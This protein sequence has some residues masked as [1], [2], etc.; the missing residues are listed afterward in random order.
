[1][2]ARRKGA[3]DAVSARVI[4]LRSHPRSFAYIANELE[5]GHAR[6]AFDAFLL[7]LKSRSAVEQ[8]S[9]RTEESGRLDDLEK[10]TRKR[11]TPEQLDKKLAAIALLR[12]RLMAVSS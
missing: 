2:P 12:E 3:D 7:A 11:S 5:L 4:E 8:R 9:L 1:M 6:D 10:R